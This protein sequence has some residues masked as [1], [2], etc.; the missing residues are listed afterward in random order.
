MFTGNEATS[1]GGAICVSVHG[2]HNIINLNINGS[3]FRQNKAVYGGAIHA[4]MVTILTSKSVFNENKAEIGVIYCTDC[5]FL[6]M[7]NTQILNNTAS[8]LI[9]SSNLTLTETGIMTVANNSS[10][11]INSTAFQAFFQQGGAITAI[12]SNICLLYTSPSPRDATLS[13]MPSSA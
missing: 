4:V 12:Q 6:L 3:I 13:R 8:L 10:P 2:I 5:R 11:N 9:I 1:V 7:Y